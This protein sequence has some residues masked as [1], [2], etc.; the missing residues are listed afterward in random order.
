MQETNPWVRK[1]P[2][3]RKWQPT[4]VSLP[5]ESHGQRNLAGYSA[6]GLKEKDVTEHCCCCCCVA[7]VVSNSAQP[8]RRQPTRLLH[9]WDFPGKS[10]GV[11]CHC[12]LHDWAHAH[13]NRIALQCLLSRDHYMLTHHLFQDRPY[14][15]HYP[16]P[17]ALV[18]VS[19][20][21]WC[22][23][24]IETHFNT[25]RLCASANIATT[26]AVAKVQTYM[27]KSTGEK[28]DHW[29]PHCSEYTLVRKVG[30]KK[31]SD[32]YQW[33]LRRAITMA[34]FQ[35]LFTPNCNL[36][37]RGLWAKGYDR[38]FD[39]SFVHLLVYSSHIFWAPTMRQTLSQGLRV[40]WRKHT[41]HPP[42]PALQGGDIH[43]A[44]IQLTQDAGG[45]EPRGG[46]RSMVGGRWLRREQVPEK[47]CWDGLWH[48][49]TGRAQR[50]GQTQGSRTWEQEVDR[51]TELTQGPGP[52]QILWIYILPH[53]LY[54]LGKVLKVNITSDKSYWWPD[55]WYSQGWH[56]TTVVLPSKPKLRDSLWETVYKLPDQYCSKL[57]R[58]SQ[59]QTR[60]SQTQTSCQGHHKHKQVS[61]TQTSLGNC[62]SHRE[63]KKTWQVTRK[64]GILDGILEHDPR[65]KQFSGKLRK[66]E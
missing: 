41:L 62:H 59:T 54:H 14:Q 44:D 61:Q 20:R 52:L 30:S 21:F 24:L 42:G 10:T 47:G 31:P 56:V 36:R 19:D 15:L 53:I 28:E 17:S 58:S 35:A 7:S 48:E 25:P 66:F 63:S 37:C 12:L 57:S 34:T 65:R 64:C 16:L 5:G 50:E 9:P 26:H 6:W 33:Y 23:S 51:R 18:Y 45:D 13:V 1:I 29:S 2:W 43:Q 32:P 39:K 3:S 22:I 27:E 46:N 4:P 11:G 8:H 40:Q 38:S 49:K 55:P 60:S